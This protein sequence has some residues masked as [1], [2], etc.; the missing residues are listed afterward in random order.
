MHLLVR[1]SQAHLTRHQ[2]TG[3]CG[4]LCDGLDQCGD[5]FEEMLGIVEHDDPAM[6]A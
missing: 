4:A 2:N 3:I 5:G 1:Q 6:T